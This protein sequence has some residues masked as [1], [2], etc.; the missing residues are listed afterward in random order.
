[1]YPLL[2][3]IFFI[4]LFLSVFLNKLCQYRHLIWYMAIL[5]ASSDSF[6]ILVIVVLLFLT[7]LIVSAL[8]YGL[9]IE[10]RKKV[11]RRKIKK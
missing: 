10:K 5:R 2:L 9:Y 1:M 8:I 3:V 6:L 7:L 11:K 4:V